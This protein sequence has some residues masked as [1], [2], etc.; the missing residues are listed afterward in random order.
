MVVDGLLAV[1]NTHAGMAESFQLS[2]PEG[3]VCLN[4]IHS[5]HIFR[6]LNPC[7]NLP[8]K[9]WT[10]PKDLSEVKIMNPLS[11]GNGHLCEVWAQCFTR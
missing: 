4:G 1:S 8:P 11:A 7:V 3:V 2:P 5:P 9:K 10:G 6:L